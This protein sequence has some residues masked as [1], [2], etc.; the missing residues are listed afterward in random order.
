MNI[1]RRENEGGQQLLTQ[2]LHAA[3]EVESR[4]ERAVE[5]RGLSLAK[6]GVLRSLVTKGGSLPLG[7]LADMLSCVRSNVTQLVDRLEAEGLVRREPDPQDRRSTLA[8]ITEEGRERY[9]AASRAREEAEREI[10]GGMSA[11]RRKQLAALLH[12]VGTTIE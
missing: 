5:E 11:E 9:E 1:S 2:L 7:R 10:L 12:E 6:L 8:V 3:R 4:L